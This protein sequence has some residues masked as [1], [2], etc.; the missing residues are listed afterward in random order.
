MY[1]T[2]NTE[3]LLAQYLIILTMNAVDRKSSTTTNSNVQKNWLSKTCPTGQRL[4]DAS[5]GK[6]L[7]NS[8]APR[9]KSIDHNTL[10]F[11]RSCEAVIVVCGC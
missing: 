11:E 6:L 3:K 7:L 5:F 1:L 2:V 10:Y 9:Q 4:I 8:K